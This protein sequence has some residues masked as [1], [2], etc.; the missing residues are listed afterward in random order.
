MK[1]FMCCLLTMSKIKS[2]DLSATQ[3]LIWYDCYLV[4]NILEFMNVCIDYQGI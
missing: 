4:R 1:D 2:M 3:C